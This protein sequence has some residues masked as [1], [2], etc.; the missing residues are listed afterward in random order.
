VTAPDLLVRVEGDLGHLTLNAPR[1]INAL[2]IGM[3][4]G[5]TA[6]LRE[7]ADAPRI[8][9]VCIDGAGDR[10]LC[11]GGDVKRL[12]AALVGVPPGPEATGPLEFWSAEYEMNAL[13]AEFTP[14]TGKPLVALMDG[15]VMGGGWGISV[16]AGVRLVTPRSVLAMPET[17]IGLVP[18][19][20]ALF[21][22]SRMPGG[23]GM[24]AA[25]TGARLNAGDAL[26]LGLAD[27]CCTA[28]ATGEVAAALSDG[29]GHPG[30]R[31]GARGPDPGL[32]PEDAAAD[33]GLRS[34]EPWLVPPPAPSLGP[35]DRE[36]IDDCFTADSV[37]EI[38][39]RLGRRPEPAAA[40]ALTALR[41]MSPTCVL[42]AFEALRRARELPTVRRV[43]EQD[44]RVSAA[45]ARH[46]DL[47]EGIRAVLV[48][49]DRSPRWTPDRWEDVPP[50]D[51]PRFFS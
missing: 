46:P 2:T 5:I 16:H 51:V 31:R 21:W 22:L 43:L 15:I 10:G 32:R 44:L 24:L 37:P 42:V 40:V 4:R 11:A 33:P 20:G 7:W 12:Y 30:F 28:E 38:A 1:R 6:A 41:A 34:I 50:A 17:A 36:W 14:V 8:A 47:A 39:D 19:V 45:C 23:V 18:D 13:V 27:A 3:V 9:V 29:G 35:A 25:L 49:K 26:E 48:D